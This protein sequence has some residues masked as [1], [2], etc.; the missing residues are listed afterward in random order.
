ML[1]VRA[2]GS[3]GSSDDADTLTGIFNQLGFVSQTSTIQYDTN[4]NGILNVGDR[5]SDSGDLRV[6]SLIA[7]GFIDTEGLW[8]GGA[9][10]L[11]AQWTGLTGYVAE[12][13]NADPTDT[14][15]GLIYDGGTINFY[16]D[17]VLDSEFA[18]PAVSTPPAGAGGTGFANGTKV[19]ALTLLQGEGHTFI[20]FT[21]GDLAS[22]G[23]VELSLQFTYMLPGFWLNALGV[24]LL[25]ISPINW[26]FMTTDMNIDTPT[27][28]NGVPSDALYTAY[29][30]QNGSADLTVVPE[31]STLLLLGGGLLGLAFVGRKKSRKS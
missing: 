1:D 13:D 12:L 30:N 8:A 11:T 25:D 26:H 21:G 23:S 4:G 3:T 27:N 17:T 31:P 16:L 29:S 2:A 10:E 24:D 22:Q 7:R 9:Y 5:F 14:R 19:A 20:D 18:N 15:L 6:E 28:D